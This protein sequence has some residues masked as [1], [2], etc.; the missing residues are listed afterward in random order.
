MLKLISKQ[1]YYKIKELPVIDT[2]EHLM[3]NEAEWADSGKDVLMEYLRDYQNSNLISAGLSASDYGKVMSV[4]ISVAEKW[5]I[6]E[7]YWEFCR[8]TGYTRALDIAVRELYGVDSIRKETIEELNARYLAAR[9][10]GHYEKV[11][12]EVC[13]I[14]LSLLDIQANR[15]FQPNPLFQ[16]IW[17]PTNFVLPG[18]DEGT[19]TLEELEKRS[20]QKINNID[21]WINLVE[22]ELD[23]HT[24]RCGVRTIKIGI[25]YQRSLKFEKTPYTEARR[26]FQNSLEEHRSFPDKNNGYM[27]F[28][29]ELQ[30]FM[31]HYIL[32]LA[33]K[34]AL[35]VQIHTG[36]FE[37]N[38]NLGFAG[39]G[40]TLSNSDPLLLNNL[41]LDYPN[42][43]F[44]LFHIGYP[45]Q[46]KVGAL[47]KMFQNVT[48]DMCWAQM[49]SPSAAVHALD[50]YL[51]AVPYNK[52]SAFGGD[53]HLIDGVYGHL[54][55]AR[56]NVSNVLAKKILEG[57][58]DE[59]QALKIAKALFYENPKR[60]FQLTQQ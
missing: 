16:N 28:A 13:N 5:R 47:A 60:I 22:S 40:N 37:G 27:Q 12:R 23:W 26:L 3:W 49:I 18:A 6:L 15:P 34:R 25:A 50:D 24:I 29:N 38:G 17:R 41:F 45:W 51:D 20:K 52:I 21:D 42:V 35:T 44:D 31:M 4:D 56:Q 43:V 8:H 30:D 59:D 58:F 46:Q 9:K 57:I 7:P 55:L 33:N 48:I 39:N 10:P 1:L 36:L 11:L 2:H 54:T 32:M 19:E 14:E 53:Y